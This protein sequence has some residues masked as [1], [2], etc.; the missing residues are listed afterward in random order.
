MIPGLPLG[1]LVSPPS[2]LLPLHTPLFQ[3]IPALLQ[4]A[5]ETSEKDGRKAPFLSPAA[6]WL[7]VGVPV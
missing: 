4:Q 7:P 3:A 5:E 2:P 1:F 6:S